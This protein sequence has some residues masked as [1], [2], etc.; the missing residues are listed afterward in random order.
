MKSNEY[1]QSKLD[2]LKQSLAAEAPSDK[3]ALKAEIFRLLMSKKFRKYSVTSEYQ[4]H[5]KNAI[6]ICVD[7]NEPIKLVLFFG[8]Y[9]L[10]RLEESPQVDW[11]EMFSL[12]YYSD[13]LRPVCQIYRPGVWFDFFFD[14]T[15]AVML[16]NLDPSETEE[17][18][19]SFL[20]LLKLIKEFAPQNLKFTCTR[21]I[22]QYANRQEF[23][24]DLQDKMAKL[25]K[26]LGDN[27]S[28]LD[29]KRRE[30]IEMNVKVSEEQKN[31]PKWREKVALMH[32]AHFLLSKSRPYYITDNKIFLS[33]ARITIGALAVGTTKRTIAKF[34]CGVGVL[35]KDGDDFH[36]L[37]LSPKQLATAKFSTQKVSIPGLVGKNFN[38]IRILD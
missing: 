2:E 25:K 29:E 18:R 28:E 11:A 27:F 38:K 15:I 12:M 10:W 37:V 19:Q 26:D 3:D 1:I 20:R 32:D 30:I 23:E 8:G 13:W 6:S 4:Q 24:D 22:D 33:T 21:L 9:K 35:Q 17:Y 36:E 7:Q 16:N 5:I 34:W 31:D 14:D